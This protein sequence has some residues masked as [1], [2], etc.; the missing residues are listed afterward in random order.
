MGRNRPGFDPQR[1]RVRRHR[2]VV[3]PL[4][5]AQS[6]QGR[7]GLAP[8]RVGRDRFTNVLMRSVEI[9]HAGQRIRQH[10]T[11][12]DVVRSERHRPPG[13]RD[14]ILEV[15]GQQ[16]VAGRF[17]LRLGVLGEK[18]G[19]AE[20]LA[21]T[22]LRLTVGNVCIRQPAPR[23]A[24]VPV[25]LHGLTELG[26]GFIELPGLEMA[27]ALGEVVLTSVRR[28]RDGDQCE[29]AEH[30][31]PHRDRYSRDFSGRMRRRL[32]SRREGASNQSMAGS[33]I[34]AGCT[35][36]GSTPKTSPAVRFSP[37]RKPSGAAKNS[38]IPPPPG[39]SCELA[40]GAV[41]CM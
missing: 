6:R 23:L 33:G 7:V 22:E 12:I 21:E 15:P 1:L 30:D 34:A 9:F 38:W 40:T 8:R 26:D 14:R 19:R 17:Y 35:E 4:H 5:D 20:I 11:G 2:L 13:T 24:P 27:L 10:D 32:R 39:P 41:N 31:R 36:V 28:T 29:R 3:A 16:E 25:L 37:G 18:V